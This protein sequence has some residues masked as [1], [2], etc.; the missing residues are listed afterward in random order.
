[1]VIK[2]D[3]NLEL[4]KVGTPRSITMDLTSPER[5]AHVANEELGYWCSVCSDPI[6]YHV[7]AGI[8]EEWSRYISR[9]DNMS[10]GTLVNVSI[11]GII[12]AWYWWILERR[13]KDGEWVSLCCPLTL[14]LTSNPALF[15]STASPVCTRLV[16]WVIVK[17]M[18]YSSEYLAFTQGHALTCANTLSSESLGHP[19]V[20]FQFRWRWNEYTVSVFIYA[21][22]PA[23]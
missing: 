20:Q 11:C 6:Q 2:G 15:C 16:W 19:S 13:L 7:S 9:V 22:H 8:C 18:C 23:W 14:I 5:G 17:L 4:D 3:F 12:S 10:Y 1:M 21:E